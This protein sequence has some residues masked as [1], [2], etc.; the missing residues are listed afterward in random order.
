MFFK[1]FFLAA[2]TSYEHFFHAFNTVIVKKCI[3]TGAMTVILPGTPVQIAITLLIVFADLLFLMKLEPYED[4][5]DDFLA[6]TTGTQM[7]LTLMLAFLLFTDRSG[8]VSTGALGVMMV[9]INLVSLFVFTISCIL[10]H[11]KIRK[12]LEA[13]K[14]ARGAPQASEVTGGDQNTISTK[15]SPIAVGSKSHDAEVLRK[16]GRS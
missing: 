15:V 14:S 13:R 2:A 9:T 4:H 16:W 1:S 6:F 8:D 12:K 11:P 10:L 7:V 5:T 3:I